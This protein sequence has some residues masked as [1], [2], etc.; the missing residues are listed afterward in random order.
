MKGFLGLDSDFEIPK[1]FK[2]DFPELDPD[3]TPEP[4]PDPD[5]DPDPMPEPEP[6][7]DDGISDN[8]HEEDMD[9]HDNGMTN[10]F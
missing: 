4:D 9:Y 5:P 2:P 6:E 10:L 3:P 8:G 7:P 1:D